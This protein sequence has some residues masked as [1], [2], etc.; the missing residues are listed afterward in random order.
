MVDPSSG[1]EVPGIMVSSFGRIAPLT[2]LISWGRRTAQGYYKTSVQ[3]Q[4]FLV[5]RLVAFAFLGPPPSVQKVVVNHKDLDKGNNAAENLEWVSHAEN[6][7]HFHAT[8]ALG[9]G[10]VAKQIWSRPHRSNDEWT[11]HHSMKSAAA[12][13][14]LRKHQVSNCTCRKLHQ[15]GGYEFQ[16]SDAPHM[17]PLLPGEEWRDVDLLLLQKDREIRGL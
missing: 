14:G 15:A 7:S 1:A 2:G 10:T 4:N 17:C 9:R 3:G 13:L 12:E 16:L 11:W 5:H 8:S 6:M